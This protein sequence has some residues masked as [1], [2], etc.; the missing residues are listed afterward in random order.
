MTSI[1]GFFE[2]SSCKTTSRNM[3]VKIPPYL[4]NK[5]SFS[6]KRTLINQKNGSLCFADSTTTTRITINLLVI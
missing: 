2:E 6:S 3:Q 1:R 4:P 5:L